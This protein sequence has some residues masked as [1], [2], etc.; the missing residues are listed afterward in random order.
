METTLRIF[1]ILFKLLLLSYVTVVN[2]VL[3]SAFYVLL[4]AIVEWVAPSFLPGL[5]AQYGFAHHLVYSLPF[6]IVLLYILYSLSPLNVWLMR[7]K[8]GYRPLGG[9]ERVRLER[10]LSEM[11]MERKLNIY[12]NR[13]A[14]TNA[15]TFGFNTIGLT[16]GILRVATDEEL[17]VSI[18]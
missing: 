18:R 15:V 17:K 8:E 4:L 12:R 13:D 16:D 7:M 2:L 9:E 10:L 5:S 3:I 11:G 1:R 6:Y 14:R